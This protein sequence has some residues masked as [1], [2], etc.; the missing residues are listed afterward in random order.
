MTTLRGSYVP[1]PNSRRPAPADAETVLHVRPFGSHWQITRDDLSA[2]TVSTK[3]TAVTEAGRQARA[4]RPSRIVVHTADD[5]VEAEATYP[6]T[7]PSPA[8]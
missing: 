2:F 3:A 1:P 7:G 5:D 6:V 4:T 8:A